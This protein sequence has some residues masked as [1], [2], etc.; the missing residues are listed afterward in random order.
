MTDLEGVR[1]VWE[2]AARTDP[3]YAICSDPAKRYGGWSEEEFFEG[4]RVEMGV[5][6][7]RLSTLQL[8]LDRSGPALDFGC[9][10]GRVTRSLARH[11]RRVVGVDIASSMI[12][13][14]M[15]LNSGVANCEFRLNDRP[16]LSGFPTDH[17][18]FVYSNIVLQHVEPRFAK[19]YVAEFIRVLRPGALAVFQLPN[20]LRLP[21]WDRVR[22]AVRLRTRIRELI[23]PDRLKDDRVEW[24]MHAVPEH[25]VRDV[26]TRSGARVVDVALTNATDPAFAGRLVY[27]SEV[28]REG[29]VSVQYCVVKNLGTA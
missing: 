12:A 6:L 23:N 22:R 8:P 14:A 1:D 13:G 29:W 5:V 26:V 18:A 16:D 19:R 21:I 11:F 20:S 24:E 2:R 7:D 9:G 28:P 17:F 4:G 27:L 10:L 25:E 3:L 15:R